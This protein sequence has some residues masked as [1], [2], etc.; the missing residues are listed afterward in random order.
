MAARKK[1]SA[2]KTEGLHGVALVER[3]IAKIESDGFD[4]FGKC[5]MKEVKK[6]APIAAAA[7]DKLAFPNG[8]PLSPALE[9][10]LAYDASWLDWFDDVKKPK[11][12]PKKLGPYTTDEYGMDWGY[13]EGL[14]QLEGDCYG[15]HFGSDSRRFLYVGKPD[16]Q[17]EYPVL[18]TDTD[19]T[20]YL[21]VE[22]PGIDVYL[23]IYAGVIEAEDRTYNALS[24]D[25]RYGARMKEHAKLNLFG[26]QEIEVGIDDINEEVAGPPP[27]KDGDP[28][29]DGYTVGINPFTQEKMLKKRRS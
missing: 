1:S 6:P 8:A 22:Y 15:L 24:K 7:L 26:R 11:F 25:A 10:W 28:I 16:T 29:P 14:P 4:V 13:G 23:A 5:G 20:P 21:C 9:R 17:G 19:D 2:K 27:W 18:L 12:K 3:V